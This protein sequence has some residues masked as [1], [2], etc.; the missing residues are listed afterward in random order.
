MDSRGIR[1]NRIGM[2]TINIAILHNKSPWLPL[3]WSA[4]LPGLGHLCLGNY[5]K[6]LVLMSWEIII[7]FKAN[8]NLAILYTFVGDFQKAQETI[9][10]GWAIFY[11]VVFSF[12]IFDSYKTCVEYNTLSLIEKEQ[13]K[14][15]TRLYVIK[16]YGISYLSKTN[17]W[18]A[19]GWS[20]LLTGFGHL[21][22]SKAFKGIILLGWMIVILIYSNIDDAIIETFLG[23]FKKVNSVLNYQWLMF[24]PSLYVFAMWDAYNDAVEMNKLFVQ[25][26]KR[27]LIQITSQ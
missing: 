19:M 25:N 4:A 20:A 5:F 26:L 23:N 17:P 12:S 24:F 13:K 2:S 1:I 22:N 3:W 15:Y 10:L 21:Y 11:G 9:H 6:G 14:R 16:S 7:N 27:R 8:L 18:C